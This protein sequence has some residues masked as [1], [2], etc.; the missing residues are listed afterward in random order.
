MLLP[1]TEGLVRVGKFDA[2]SAMFSDNHYSRQTPG[3]PQ[4]MPPGKTLVLR[5]WVGSVLFGWLW[6][7]IRDDGQRGYNCCIFRNESP[8]LASEIILEAEEFA[9]K[10]WGPNRLFTYIDPTQTRPIYR[11]SERCVGWSWRKAGW[12]PLLSKNGDQRT[13]RDGAWLFV[14][15]NHQPFQELGEF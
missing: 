14:K 3:S 1:F 5:N 10:E 11:R 9:F 15:L 13:S 8:R 6:Q 2:E 7:E 12:R 4:F